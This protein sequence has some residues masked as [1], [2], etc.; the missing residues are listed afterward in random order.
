MAYDVWIN[1][2]MVY[3]VMINCVAGETVVYTY[4]GLYIQ[5]AFESCE[6]VNTTLFSNSMLFNC[7]IENVN[8]ITWYLR[9]NWWRIDFDYCSRPS[10]IQMWKKKAE[11]SFIYII[12]RWVCHFVSHF[13]T[14]SFTDGS[15]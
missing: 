3:S 10:E 7:R 8:H 12:L 1:E 4:Q 13:L 9:S 5:S 2:G 11:V 15:K 14:T 6:I